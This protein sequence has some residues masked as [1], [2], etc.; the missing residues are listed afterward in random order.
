MLTKINECEYLESCFSEKC[1]LYYD[2]I[3]NIILFFV[4]FF[5]GGFCEPG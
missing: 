2:N 4:L 3:L 5:T 1:C